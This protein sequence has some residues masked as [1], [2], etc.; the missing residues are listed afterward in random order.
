MYTMH[1]QRNGWRAP[2]RLQSEPTACDPRWIPGTAGRRSR[3]FSRCYH[4]SACTR[5]RASPL[6]VP[7]S[8]GGSTR[9]GTPASTRLWRWPPRTS[10]PPRSAPRRRFRIVHRK[11][12]RNTLVG[13]ENKKHRILVLVVYIYTHKKYNELFAGYNNRII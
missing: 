10:R 12:T 8:I 13:K 9:T 1:S 7:Y 5:T 2:W 6:F 4:P 11:T 3:A